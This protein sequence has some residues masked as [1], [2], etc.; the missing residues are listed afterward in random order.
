MLSERLGIK[1]QELEDDHHHHNPAPDKQQQMDGW[2]FKV[3]KNNF[4]YKKTVSVWP[5][6]SLIA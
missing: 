3:L 4:K 6:F 1:Q 5:H 2:T